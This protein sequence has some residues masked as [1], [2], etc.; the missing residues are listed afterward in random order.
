MPSE[1]QAGAQEAGGKGHAAAWNS[2][3]RAVLGG[4][5]QGDRLKCPESHCLIVY[6]MNCVLVSWGC[7][8]PEMASGPVYLS[9]SWC[10]GGMDSSY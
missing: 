3:L 9:D 10:G 8:A 2:R 5:P 7:L 1:P 6:P 4:A